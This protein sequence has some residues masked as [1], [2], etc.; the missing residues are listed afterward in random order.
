MIENKIC[1]DTCKSQLNVDNSYPHNY[2][3]QLSARDYGINTTGIEYAI[4]QFPPLDRDYDFCD[5]DCM[6]KWVKE[7]MENVWNKHVYY[8]L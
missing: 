5:M 8:E 4:C 6:L 3:I 7:N 2:G 1:C